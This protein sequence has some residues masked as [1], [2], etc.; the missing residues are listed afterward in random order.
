MPPYK[1]LTFRDYSSTCYQRHN[2]KQSTFENSHRLTVGVE[3]GRSKCPHVVVLLTGP[4]LGLE[5]DTAPRWQTGDCYLL[6]E[7]SVSRQGFVWNLKLDSVR[8]RAPWQVYRILQHNT[9]LAGERMRDTQTEKERDDLA[10]EKIELRNQFTQV[11]TPTVKWRVSW[12]KKEEYLEFNES[13]F[14]EKKGFRLLYYET[15]LP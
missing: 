10:E 13:S 1:H 11:Y 2:L 14:L 6:S 4:F 12:K 9:Q 3:V 7:C 5:A 15:K 8:C